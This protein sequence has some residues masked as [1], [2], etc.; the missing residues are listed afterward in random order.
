MPAPTPTPT[1]T[2]VDAQ[3]D[4]PITGTV[5]A[6]DADGSSTCAL[7]SSGVVICWGEMGEPNDRRRP[8]VVH[9][10]TGAKQLAIGEGHGCVLDGSNL[11]C[12]GKNNL[13][14]LGASGTPPVAPLGNRRAS[15]V[16]ARSA[17]TCALLDGGA[18]E[19]WGFA[20]SRVAG[21]DR[22]EWKNPVPDALPLQRSPARIPG[23]DEARELVLG[24]WAA[25]VQQRG[26]AVCW[27]TNQGSQLG[28]DGDYQLEP[29]PMPALTGLKHLSLGHTGACGVDEKEQA[30]CTGFLLMPAD[31]V[32]FNSATSRHVPELDG[33]IAFALGEFHSCAVLGNGRVRCWGDNT[34]GQLGDQ[35]TNDSD[36]PVEVVGLDDAVAVAVGT[37]HTCVLTKSAAVKCWGGNAFGQLGDGTDVKNRMQPTAVVGVPSSP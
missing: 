18:V 7:L 9:G 14:Q 3:L 25:C 23:I 1:P 15:Q 30:R 34:Y 13:W 8:H 6:I 28:F 35:T 31:G 33:A 10:I 17:T 11:S 29:A 16:A 5:T 19:C 27:G 26:K 21:E 12:W 20:L 37:Q 32:P 4:P 2:P 22:S 24:R 36:S